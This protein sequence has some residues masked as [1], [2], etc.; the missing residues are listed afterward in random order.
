MRKQ[1]LSLFLLIAV[2]GLSFAQLKDDDSTPYWSKIKQ[3]VKQPEMQTDY[4]YTPSP[5]VIRKYQIFGTEAIVYPNVRPKPTTNTTQSEMSIDIH[6]T[7]PDIIFGSANATPWPVA[8]IYGT[9][10]YWTTNGGTAWSGYDNPPFGTNSGDPAGAIGTNGNFYIGFIDGG[11]NDG[12]QGV[13]VSTNNGQ[14]WTRYVVG[15]APPGFNDLLDKN[16]LWVDKKVGS[17]YENRVYAAWTDF[18]SGSANNYC[19][20]FKYSTNNGQT[21]STQKNISVSLANSYLDQGVNIATGP[22]GEVYAAWAIYQDGTVSTGEDG[23]GFNVSTDGGETWGTPRAIY[24]KSN[25][26]IRGT[27]SSKAGIRVASFPSMSVNRNTG[28]IYIVFPQKGNVAPSGNSIDIVMIK[29]TDGGT[30]WTTGTRVNNDPTNNSKDQYYPWC[31]VDQST[32][33]LHVVFYDSRDVRND[34]AEVFMAS[35]F[36]GGSTFENFKVSDQKFKP[37]AISGLAGG[38]QG[39]Y[40]GITALNNV[41]YPYWCDDRT[42]IYQGWLSKVVVATYPLNP[43]NLTSPPNNGTLTSFPNSS[44]PN[45]I[46]WDTASSTATYK[47]II[48]TPLNPRMLELPAGSN[49]FTLTNGQLDALLASQGVNAGDSIFAIWDVWAY[50]N[51]APQNDSLKSTNGPWNIILKR[52]KP[53]LIPFNLLTPGDNSTIV[54]SVFNNTPVTIRWN[55]SGEGVNYKWKFGTSLSNDGES[56]AT[57]LELPSGNGGFD[58]SITLL[59]SALDAVLAGIGLQPGQ[60]SVGQWTV[61]GYSGFDSLKAIQSFNLT[62]QR[63]AKGSVLLVYDSTSTNGRVSKDSVANILGRQAVTFDLFNKGGQTSTNV[64]SLRGYD[65]LIWLGEGTSVMSAVQKDSVKAYLTNPGKNKSKLII[66][67]EDIG[68]QLGRSASSY[69]DL[70]FVNNYLGFNFVLDRPSSGGAQAL[71]WDYMPSVT[72]H[73]DSTIGTWPDVLSVFNSANGNGL[74]KFNDNSFNAVGMSNLTSTVVVWGVDIESMRRSYFSPDTGSAQERAVYWALKYVDL[75]GFIPVELNSFNA[76]V[77]NNLVSLNW[78]TATETNNKGFEVQRRF[79]DQP[80]SVIGFVEGK[81]TISD[82]QDYMFID[83]TS[84][85]GKYFYRLRQIDLDGTQ[86]FSDEIEVDVIAPVHFSLE[87]NYPNPFNPATTI[88]YAVPQDGLVNL[89][90]YNMLGE[91]VATLINEVQIAGHYEFNLNASKFASGIYFY[92]L[93]SGK[94]ISIKK[95]ALIK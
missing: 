4:I 75:S 39:D 17:P 32:G 30:T 69:Y 21:W 84:V 44:T 62:L 43:F 66:F 60:S 70:D 86:S 41:V 52:G 91:K 14:N 83:K 15:A 16:H 37:K 34:S 61:Y 46:S 73:K 33:A 76:N 77:D 18:Y 9:G 79:K 90:V 55:R 35:S 26:G 93:E 53:A 40:I 20:A 12:G 80:F 25:F 48:G 2:S 68:Y 28:E 42:G 82:Q 56:K 1:F 31:T 94:N 19:L 11:S 51:N 38:Y 74:V 23:I 95:M 63:Q 6:P 71:T 36:D 7:N 49:V 92:R 64:I 54:T 27:L 8:G 29:S 24:L 47:I 67:S 50:R 5:Q 45:I 57:L 72:N 10:V 89:S 13:A 58:T 65:R 78:T 85:S 81:G 87:Q 88:K 22:N 59:N 3:D